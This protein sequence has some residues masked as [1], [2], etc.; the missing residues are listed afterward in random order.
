MS[1]L[2]GGGIALLLALTIQNTSGDVHLTLVDSGAPVVQGP[3]TK[4]WEDVRLRVSAREPIT[5]QTVSGDIRVEVRAARTAPLTLNTVSGD[6][7]LE[8]PPAGTLRISLTSGDV[9]FLGTP[10]EEPGGVYRVRT[11]SGNLRGGLPPVSGRFR[12]LSGDLDLAFPHPAPSPVWDTL[13]AP[14]GQLQVSVQGEPV[15]L[16]TPGVYPVGGYHLV[17]RTPGPGAPG[18]REKAGRT[19]PGTLPS[20]T[21]F[22]LMPVAPEGGALWV[23]YNRVDGLS[24]RIP[25]V[26]SRRD[27][28]L[29]GLRLW[30]RV[31]LATTVAFGRRI[32]GE[33]QRWRERLGYWAGTELGIQPG[34][35]PGGFLWAEAWLHQT[36][37]LQR[38]TLS[39]W[40]NLLGSVLAK[41]DAYDYYLS[42]GGAVGLGLRW[43]P[44][45][46]LRVGYHLETVDSLPVTQQFSVFRSG[47]PFRSNPPAEP[48]EL[49]GVQLA[50]EARLAGLS[51]ALWGIH[52]T[53]SGSPYLWQA[54]VRGRWRYP[55]GDLRVRLA[56]GGTTFSPPSPLAFSLGGLGTVPGYDLHADS[57][58]R[59][60]LVNAETRIAVP[61]PDLLLFA[62]A[63]RIPGHQWLTDAGVGLTLA[64]LALR[65]VAPLEN[66]RRYRV[67]LRWLYWF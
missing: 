18:L 63:G 31:H 65:W 53:A 41:Y 27:Q 32:P 54:Q 55:L 5:V 8:N 39:P 36:A 50:A 61:G 56:T 24:L 67:Y 17:V 38:W 10:S 44:Y 23:N 49:Q 2:T 7:Y 15:P 34:H 13:E 1:L 37:T 43:Q 28:T 60:L 40:E 62:D 12:S 29:G 21:V 11:L 6:V 47:D 4:T 20:E 46:W 58:R 48:T 51:L 3:I 26:S 52:G 64:S 42:S 19:K 14:G 35:R 16:D 59:F 45:L 22:R 33:T 57:G 66:P 9:Y 30:S 25:L